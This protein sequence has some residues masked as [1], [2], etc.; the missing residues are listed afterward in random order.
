MRLNV[1]RFSILLLVFA[2]SG[3]GNRFEL[4]PDYLKLTHS[5]SGTWDSTWGEMKLTQIGDR[6]KGTYRRFNGL[7]GSLGGTLE[8]NVLRFNWNEPGDLSQGVLARKGRG[9]F[10]LSSDGKR[11]TGEW[12]YDNNI[13]DGGTWTAK[14][15]QSYE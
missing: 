7:G 13:R 5:F 15:S 6:V 1:T 4:K 14:R 3:C 2:L 11:L 10:K 8:G 9:Y 12:G